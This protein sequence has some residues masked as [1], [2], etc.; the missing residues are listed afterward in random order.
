M[1]IFFMVLLCV[2]IKTFVLILA[3][4]CNLSTTKA[5]RLK[6]GKRLLTIT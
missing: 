4:F 5:Q 3:A 6:L 1:F 2:T